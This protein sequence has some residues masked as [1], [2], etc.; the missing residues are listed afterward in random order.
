MA[1]GVNVR[2]GTDAG[3]RRPPAAPANAWV[4]LCSKTGE[5]AFLAG[6]F[7]NCPAC[8]RRRPAS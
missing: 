8:Y 4:H 5:S 1:V 6:Y 2:G 3:R 7:R